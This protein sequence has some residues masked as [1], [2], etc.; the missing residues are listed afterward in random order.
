MNCFETIIQIFSR[1]N[2]VV[3]YIATDG[4]H[5][6]DGLHGSF[7]EI[8]FDLNK[9]NI[10]FSLIIQ[11]LANSKISRIPLSDFLCLIKCLRNTLV[12]YGVTIENKNAVSVSHELLQNFN[13]GK[14]LIDMCSHGKMKDS[15]PL[16]I[17]R[18][19]H[20]LDSIEKII[21]TLFS[22]YFHSIC[23]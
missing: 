20:I 14:P 3:D 10:S 23:S 9:S 8:I 18:S 13:L 6:Y 5:Q 19:K 21:T 11:T 16:E 12:K 7:F 17:L 22:I 15:Y 2:I 1:K 4:D